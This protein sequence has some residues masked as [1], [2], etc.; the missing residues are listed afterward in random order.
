[1]F[2]LVVKYYMNLFIN[3]I[4]RF[5]FNLKNF[6]I[7]LSCIIFLS[8]FAEFNL[9]RGSKFFSFIQTK[10]YDLICDFINNKYANEIEEYSN[11]KFENAINQKK[12]WVVW[13]QGESEFPGIVKNCINS[14]D[15]YS[16]DYELVIITK[17]NYSQY[18][19]LPIQI[20]EKV[21]SGK[22]SFTNISDILRMGLLSSYGGVWVDSTIFVSDFI[23]NEFDEIEYNSLGKCVTFF[24]GG[25]SNKLFSFVYDIL[26]K[27]SLEYDIF[28]DYFFLNYII[29]VAYNSFDDCREYMD[30][31][32]FKNPYIFY[33]INNFSKSFNQESFDDICDKYKFFKL[34][35]KPSKNY[36]MYDS[37]GNIT[38]WGY[39]S[40]ESIKR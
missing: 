32:T 35:Y 1:M 17:D 22:L 33:F 6:G 2:E 26:I 8:E 12:I 4:H 28:I 19:D 7:Y 29:E 23:F 20:L 10:K 14:I 15:S 21:E 5:F 18:V 16:G 11:K 25:K 37:D 3:S 38:Y 40:N 24:M 36:K 27:Y 13:W 31:T 9:I 34:S 30:N 39:F